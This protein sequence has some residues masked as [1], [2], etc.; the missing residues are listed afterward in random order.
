MFSVSEHCAYNQV[1][2]INKHPD[3]PPPPPEG[4]TSAPPADSG[5]CSWSSVTSSN[6]SDHAQPPSYMEAISDGHHVTQQNSL[7]QAIA[8]D[9]TSSTQNLVKS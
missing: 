9:V 7:N 5:E 6:V 2:P 4:A 1:D 8:A 3:Y